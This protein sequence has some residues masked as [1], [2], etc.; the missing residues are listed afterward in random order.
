MEELLQTEEG[1]RHIEKILCFR[2][3]KII[4]AHIHPDVTEYY[5][6]PWLSLCGWVAIS[7]GGT[8]GTTVGSTVLYTFTF[9]VAP[10]CGGPGS[11]V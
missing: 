7:V 11:R 5:V 3:T 2:V 8:V 4:S 9:T 6:R 10:A 1:P